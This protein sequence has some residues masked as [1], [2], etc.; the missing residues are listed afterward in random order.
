MGLLDDLK[1]KAESVRTHE[2]LRLSAH[3]ENLQTV[4]AAMRR[5]FSYLHELLEQLKVIKPTNAVIYRL[6]GIGELCDLAYVDSF[7]S[8][9]I[10]LIEDKEH[11]DRIDLFILW[12]AADDLVVE[13]DMPASAAKL[14]ELLWNANLRFVEDETKGPAGNTVLTRFRIAK[15]MRMAVTLRADYA[16][17]RIVMRAK[18]LMRTGDDDFAFAADACNETL[19]EDLAHLLMGHLSDFRRHRILLPVDSWLNQK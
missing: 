14:R 6:P 10:K 2:N 7:V 1:K 16:E 13:R 19:L 17:R 5:A 12:G 4:E 8:Y 11:Y 9:R 15:G 3:V 18:N